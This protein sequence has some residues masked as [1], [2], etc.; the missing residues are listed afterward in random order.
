MVNTEIN[1]NIESSD[2]ICYEIIMDD[3]AIC[4]EIIMDE[5]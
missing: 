2:E 5:D 1:E 4:Y 3:N